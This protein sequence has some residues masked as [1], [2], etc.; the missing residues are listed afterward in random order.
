MAQASETVIGPE[1][2]S[3]VML[4]IYANGLALIRDV[5]AV[6]LAAGSHQVAFAGIS[7]QMIPNSA[8][9]FP[10]GG[11]LAIRSIDYDFDVV[12]AQALLRRHLGRE[13][14]VVRVHPRTG[15][16]TV[17]RATVLAVDEGV[18]LR[19]RDR[20]ETGAPGRIV[21]DTVPEDLRAFPT[22]SASID[23]AATTDAL[24]LRYLTDGMSW[25]ADYIV[26]LDDSAAT[27][28]LDGRATLRNV[29][30]VE[31]A[32]AQI[33][34]I[35]G[36]INRESQPS[37]AAGMAVQR[38]AD[39]APAREA[40]ADLHLYTLVSPVSLADQHTKQI[41]L[42]SADGIAFHRTY[43]SRNTSPTFGPLRGEPQ[44]SHPT[45]KLSFDNAADA[46][47]GAPLPA[48]LVRVYTADSAGKVRLLG[49]DSIPST[50]VG[51]TVDFTP[52]EAFDLTVTRRQTD[53]KRLST[54]NRLTESAWAIEVANAKAEPA[55]VRLVEILMGDWEILNESASHEKPQADRAEWE[56]T[57]PPGETVTVTY[58]VRVRR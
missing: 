5:R 24:E 21:F 35:A 23:V 1:Q 18:V 32:D 19:Y 9:I 40:F 38:M 25:S 57:V 7:R 10:P 45:V 42:H 34:L 52:G 20:I 30:G 46:G 48:G 12:S 41:V 56:V 53:F 49:E 11:N 51:Q 17:E 36:R 2:R 22:L 26:T 39:A 47:L 3:A 15:E 37:P 6:D 29:T 31:F 8:A 14:G 50:P 54:D 28:A 33:G 44:P 16:E 27:L 55:D 13:V 4:T 43:I 58:R